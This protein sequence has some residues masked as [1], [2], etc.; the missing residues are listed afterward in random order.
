MI[1]IYARDDDEAGRK[2][3]AQLQADNQRVA[4]RNPDLWAEED[5]PEAKVIKVYSDD[6]TILAAYKEAKVPTEKLT[7]KK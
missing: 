1:L 5:K 7:A 3:L 4:Y 2:L 6:E